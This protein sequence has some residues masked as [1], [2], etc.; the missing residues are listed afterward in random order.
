MAVRQR[1]NQRSNQYIAKYVFGRFLLRHRLVEK[2][3]LRNQSV[4]RLP[5]QS[6]GLRR[7]GSTLSFRDVLEEPP[8]KGFAPSPGFSWLAMSSI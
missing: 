6:S 7:N 1:G 4:L 2:D 8:E 5:A 3:E